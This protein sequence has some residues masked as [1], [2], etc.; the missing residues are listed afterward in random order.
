MHHGNGLYDTADIHVTH[1]ADGVLADQP[2]T[3]HSAVKGNT[4]ACLG[5]PVFGVSDLV[6]H[7]PGCA[8][9]DDG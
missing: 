3:A 7:R 5:K 4:K 9:T 1:V 8:I 6:Q 2:L